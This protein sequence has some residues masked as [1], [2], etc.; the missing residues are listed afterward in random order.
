MGQIERVSVIHLAPQLPLKMVAVNDL[1]EHLID[2]ACYASH[3]Q[4]FHLIDG[5]LR[6]KKHKMLS[7][8]PLLNQMY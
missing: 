2:I 6:V 8:F 4:G 1:G 7:G 5:V 3:K